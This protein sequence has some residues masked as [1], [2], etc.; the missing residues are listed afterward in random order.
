MTVNG[1][2]INR[3]ANADLNKDFIGNTQVFV[4]IGV[5]LAIIA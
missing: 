3:D 2:L 5:L 4:F 1:R